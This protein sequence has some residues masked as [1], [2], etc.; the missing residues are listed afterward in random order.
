MKKN[1]R[2]NF[3]LIE[4]LVVIA[5][6]AIL[7][8]ILLPA[9]NS[10]REKAR[11][12]ACLNNVKTIA[13]LGAFY[14]LDNN[15]YIPA[16]MTDNRAFAWWACFVQYTRGGGVNIWDNT[17]AFLGYNGYPNTMKL[18]CPASGIT[19]NTWTYGAN[20][21]DNYS[22]NPRIPFGIWSTASSAYLLR[23]QTNIPPELCMIADGAQL[24]GFNPCTNGGKLSVDCSGDGVNDSYSASV[25]YNYF[26]PLRHS[27]GLN[28][29]FMDC[30][31]SWVSFKEWQQNMNQTGFMY[32]AKYGDKK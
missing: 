4:L 13:Q 10:A 9:L 25:K 7:A 2:L 27:K 8:A 30:H 24:Y 17:R 3:T 5:I 18:F 14:S 6:I 20:Y 29:S 32:N 23:K 31:A 19:A 15:D 12:I 16:A 21:A 26:A 22:N 11:S 1:G 28:M